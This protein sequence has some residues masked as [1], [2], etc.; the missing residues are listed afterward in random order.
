MMNMA[1]LLIH[2]KVDQKNNY[3]SHR[4]VDEMLEILA[5]VI[6]DPFLVDI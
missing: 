5:K 2:P 1:K 4:I 6:E 3:R